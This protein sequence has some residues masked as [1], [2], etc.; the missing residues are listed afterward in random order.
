MIDPLISSWSD[1]NVGHGTMVRTALWLLQEVGLGNVFTKEQHRKAFSGVT[2]ADRRL[3]DLRAHGW[4]IHTNLQDVSLNQNEQ[5]FVACG[6]AVWD[7]TQ[8]RALG[9]AKLTEKQRMT[10]FAESDFQCSIC[11]IAGGEMY[12]DL[13][14]V[15]A[16]LS[17]VR[18][19]IIGH[20]GKQETVF[21]AE[22]KRCSAGAA[23]RDEDIPKFIA[24]FQRLDVDTKA[25]I[26]TLIA[27]DPK[28]QISQIWREF[29]QMSDASRS[30]I[31]KL[32]K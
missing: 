2:Q 11:G 15:S 10:V 20:A 9:T 31:R 12:A 16:T 21:R 28:A 18:R 30:Q 13:I 1:T 7:P 19:T 4:V 25:A 26:A 6:L 5:R 24:E 32:L 8:R 3:R 17:A 23:T 22:C 14:G 27:T 29:R